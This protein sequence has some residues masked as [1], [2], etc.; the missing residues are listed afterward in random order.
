MPLIGVPSQT[1][2][3]YPTYVANT[4]PV[5]TRPV[6][7][8]LARPA[9]PAVSII[10]VVPSM[11]PATTYT[12]TQSRTP[13]ANTQLQYSQPVGYANAAAP[14]VSYRFRLIF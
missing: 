7:A 2:I 14:Q 4:N 1:V 12:F 10:G 11:P 3:T 5:I 6:N 13:F 9:V 8:V